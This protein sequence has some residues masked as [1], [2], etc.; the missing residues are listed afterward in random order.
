MAEKDSVQIKK[1]LT[2]ELPQYKFS[3]TRDDFAG[4]HSVNVKVLSGPKEV[5]ANQEARDNSNGY[6]DIFRQTYKDDERINDKIK[7]DIDKM[8][9]IIYEIGQFPSGYHGGPYLHWR[10]GSYLKPYEVIGSNKS[11]PET[12][13]EKS[14]VEK[15]TNSEL[16]MSFSQGWNLYKTTINKKGSDGNPLTLVVYNLNKTKELE[17]IPYVDF[18]EF[19][20]EMLTSLNM[21]WGKFQKFEKWTY[22]VDT[23]V[24]KVIIEKYYGAGEAKKEEPIPQ[25]KEQEFKV[26]DKF[27]MTRTGE[28]FEID[29]ITNYNIDIT[30]SDGLTGFIDINKLNKGIASGYYKKVIDEEKEKVLFKKGDVFYSKLFKQKLT[31]DKVQDD[32]IFVDYEDDSSERYSTTYAK[33]MVERGDWVRVIDEEVEMPFKEGDKFLLTI[34]SVDTTLTIIDIDIDSVKVKYADG[35]IGIFEINSAKSRVERGVWKKVLD[36]EKE[37]G[38]EEDIKKAIAALEILALDGDEEA[39]K[40]IKALKI[41]LN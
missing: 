39:K 17:N 11:T 27:L 37:S 12:R 26:G 16:L 5:F 21:K 33:L 23:D 2:K 4:G 13:S 35:S 19:K 24:L 36:E 32:T 29:Y 3:I 25:S 34:N 30:Y 20:G 22:P 38:S 10:F 40:G 14:S 41:L 28:T 8:Y 9:K 31:I 15:N 18:L 1:R 6:I 7:T